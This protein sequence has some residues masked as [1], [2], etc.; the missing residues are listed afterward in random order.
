MIRLRSQ[1]VQGGEVP[2]DLLDLKSSVWGT[3]A[4]TLSWLKLFGLVDEK[5]VEALDRYVPDIPESRHAFSVYQ[6]AIKNSFSRELATGKH[7]P[8][9]NK[10]RELGIPQSNTARIRL[11]ILK[12]KN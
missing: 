3:K 2:G 6:W 12:G 11:N 1:V 5:S 7:V 8:D 9:L 4:L 10:L